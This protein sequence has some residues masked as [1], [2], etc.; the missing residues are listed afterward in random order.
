MIKN[1]K[2]LK[3]TDIRKLYEANEWYAYTNDFENLLKG[4]E[5]SLDVYAYF[6][7]EVLAGLIRVVGDGYTIIYVQ[8]ILLLPE[9]QNKGVG[10]QLL[11][12][13][14]DKY[15]SVRQK[16][17]MTDKRPEQLHF[18]RKNGFKDVT[19]IGCTGFTF[20]GNKES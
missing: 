2:E 19:E 11:K 17:L 4:I 6:E 14:L 1:T 13:V 5:N 10:T 12:T 15:E 18:Y 3:P 16:V 20:T 8:D 9:Y 7:G